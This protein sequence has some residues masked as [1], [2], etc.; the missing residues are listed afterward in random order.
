MWQIFWD[1]FNAAVHTNTNLTGVQKFNYLRA[2]LQGDAARVVAGFPLTDVNYQNSITLLRER[3]GQ[4]YK[5]INAHMQALLN[6]TNANNTLSSLQSFY[7]TVENHIRG[8]DSL[9]RSPESYGSLLT[10]IILGKL[11]KQVRKSLARDHSNVE[12]SLNELR[13]SILKEIQILET[14][15]RHHDQSFYGDIPPFT[16]SSFYT[17][18]RQHSAQQPSDTRKPAHCVYCKRQHSSNSCDVVTNPQDCLAIVKRN[19]LCFNCLARY[20]VTQ[21]NSK[22]RCRVCKRK[23]HTSLCTSSSQPSAPSGTSEPPKSDKDDSK[24]TLVSFTPATQNSS[25]P[26]P[27]VQATSCL[28]K[29]AIAIISTPDVSLEGNILFDEGAQRSFITQEI[30]T[31]LNLKPYGKDSISLASFGSNSAMHRSLSVA[32][33][34]I[35]TI[36]R[37]KIPISV[38]IVPTI[39]PPL[40]N[41]VC[42]SLKQI[43]HLKGLHLAHPVTENENFE[44]LVLIGVDYYLNFVQDHIIRGTGPTAVQSKLGYLLSG[45]LPTHSHNSTVSLFHVSTQSTKDVPNI[46]RFWSVEAAGTSPTIKEDPDK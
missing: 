19:N 24:K 46:E 8:L 36:T 18:T 37:E 44:I 30:A 26:H 3:F 42:T 15:N 23:H 1:S 10:P 35:Q 14:D 27:P 20:K 7:D 41:S 31:K 33:I 34:K 13:S 17:G 43:P 2:Q 40:Q 29:T 25:V 11:L 6:L 39:E 12:W 9:G 5:L 16:A 32:I 38:L 28:L 45:P 21:C 22:F 4:P